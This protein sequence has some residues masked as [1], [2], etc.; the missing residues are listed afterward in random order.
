MYPSPSSRG[1]AAPPSSRQ[2]NLGRTRQFY[3]SL[4]RLRELTGMSCLK[5]SDFRETMASYSTAL[6]KGNFVTERLLNTPSFRRSLLVSTRELDAREP[7]RPFVE[8]YGDALLMLAGR[9]VEGD[10]SP[11]QLEFWKTKVK[12]LLSD[13][14]DFRRKTG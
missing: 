12:L 7:L 6:F 10:M 5:A 9:Q 13:S 14:E 2:Q 11:H 4:A 1:A 8:G 3:R